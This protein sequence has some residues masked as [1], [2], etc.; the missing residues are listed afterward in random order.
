MK[1]A[2]IHADCFEY[3]KT[4][5]DKCIDLVLTDPPYILDLDG[6]HSCNNEFASRKLIKDKHIDFICNDFDYE[7]A[8]S[9]WLRLCKVPNIILFCS[10][11]QVSRTMSYFEN[12]GLKA[13]LMVW[14]KPNPVP[15][16]NMKYVG[17]LEFIIWVRDKGAYF[18]NDL[19]MHKKLKSFKYPAPATAER[20]HPTQK[21]VELMSDLINL[22]CPMGGVVLDCFSGSGATAAACHKTG[23]KYLCTEK[24]LAFY[25]ASTKRMEDLTAQGDLFNNQ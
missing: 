14:D 21:P 7:T 5:P 2:I 13:Q 11:N 12:K 15:L 20:I 8:F 19:P 9:E 18:N 3:M 25:T 17:N 4:L 16:C 6:G 10:N 24:D 23:R 22:H 1:S